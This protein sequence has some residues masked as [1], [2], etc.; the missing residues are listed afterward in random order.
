MHAGPLGSFISSL[1]LLGSGSQEAPAA[2]APGAVTTA[3]STNTAQPSTETVI[4]VPIQSYS[5]SAS[6]LP[7]Q[8]AVAGVSPFTDPREPPPVGSSVVPDF[9]QAWAGAYQEAKNK[10]A[11]FTIDEKVSV[12]TGVGWM[13]GRCVGNTPPIGEN[14]TKF[15]GLCLEDSPL[16]IRFADFVTAFPTG[17]N[18]AATFNR[19]L[20]RRRGLFMGREHVGKG[21]NVALGPMMNIGRVAQGGRNW[22]GFGADPF[23]AGEAAYE[24]ILGMQEGGVQACA[25]HLINN[26]QEHFRTQESSDVDDRTQHEIYA[27]PFLRSIMAGVASI[28]CSYNLINGTYACE[29]DKI[30]NDIIKREFGFQ[31]YVMSDWG[32]THSTISVATGLDMTMPGDITFGSGTTYFGPTLTA[33][34]QNNT[35]AE[36]RLDDMATRIIAGWY[37]LHQDAGNYPTTNFDA[38]NPANEDTNE[39][40]DVQEDHYKVVREIGAASTVLLK[41]TNGALPLKKPRS[42][43]LVGSDAGPGKVGPNEFADQGG[44][45]GILAMGWGSGTANFTYLVSPLEAIQRR[46]R[47]D[48]TSVSWIL[49]DFDTD[50][51]GNMAIGRSAALVFISSDSG[52]D[53]ITVD[54]NEGD[55]K[56]LTA[57]HSGDDL[58]LAIAAQNNN[59]IVVVHSVG[60]LIV[61]PWIDHP[62]VSAVLWAGVPGQEAGNSIMDVLYGAWNPSGRLPYTIAK[63]PSDYSAQLVLGGQPTDI[64]SIPYTEG[65]NVDY[66][67]FDSFN[68]TPRFE[69]GFG[70]SYTNFTYSKLHIAKVGHQAS[71][72]AALEKS[73]AAGNATPIGEG[74]STALWLHRPL[75]NVTFEVKNTGPVWGGDVP[76]LYLH[77]PASAGEPPSLLKG[78]T[79][80]EVLPQEQ[81]K[82]SIT[83][84]RY[85]LSFWDTVAQG[86]RRPNGTIGVSI[87]TSSR[88]VRLS[89]NIT[90]T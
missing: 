26:E 63:Q 85:D 81:K 20:I 80:V 51:A 22:E 52:E 48:R 76:Q 19:K 62:N 83:L 35:I 84:S 53:Y 86:W 57:W 65:L 25:K 16:G 15:P 69:F 47:D 31:G 55:R 54:G 72:D 6:P 3:P 29:N 89:G 73:W 58:V 11:G 7:S 38:F 40:V 56:N 30:M 28:M 9:G 43:V 46:A 12:G 17:V 2:E 87:G 44:L 24:T 8:A 50:R 42:I 37:F 45:D 88:D 77:M 90:I 32:A 82:V 60:P 78:F 21:V 36:A 68:I 14:G 5:F 79:N 59:T 61:E 66:R 67:H 23:L 70:L 71:T 49:D 10:V 13:G 74:S 1:I 4:T 18:T 27:H 41:N 75:Y 39:H 64:L 34:V 33:Y